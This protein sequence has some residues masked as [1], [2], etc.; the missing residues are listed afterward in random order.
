MKTNLSILIWV[1]AL[2]GISQA[3]SINVTSTGVGI[4]TANPAEKLEIKGNI[5]VNDA[6]FSPTGTAPI[7]GCRAWVNFD[8]TRNAS[9][10]VDASNSARYIR[11][12]GN[13]S[14]VVKVTTGCYDVNFITPMPDANYAF[15]V[16]ASVYGVSG[17]S[18]LS[19]LGFDNKSTTSIRFVSGGDYPSNSK[20]D[21]NEVSVIIFR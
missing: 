5:K 16:C 21:K 10:V 7:Y 4:G 15:S 9:G 12:S 11:A 3:Q 18:Y 13:V 14:S 2:A 8:G 20:N 1:L 17:G 6:V 19:I